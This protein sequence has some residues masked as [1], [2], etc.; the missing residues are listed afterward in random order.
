MMS[1]VELIEKIKLLPAGEQAAFAALFHEWE[2]AHGHLVPTPLG[3]P[4]QMPDYEGRLRRLFPSGGLPGDPQ[5][6][7]GFLRQDR[8]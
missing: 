2:L 4:F 5:A 7:W 8:I 3:K 6:F 1:A